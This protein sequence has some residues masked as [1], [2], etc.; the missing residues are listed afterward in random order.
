MK[1]DLTEHS[2]PVYE[3]LASPVRL[4]VLRLLA[5][6]PM[7]IKELAGAVGLSSAIMTMHVRKLAEAGL[8]ATQMAPGK[9]GLQKICSLAVSQTEI[10][11]SG[12]SPGHKSHRVEIPVGHYSDFRIEPTCGLATPDKII[13]NFDD[14]RYF[15]EPERINAGVLWLGKGFI[16]YKAPNYLLSSQQ[17]R[18]LV[19]TMEIASEA[20]ATNNNYPSDI[21]FTFN[22][23]VVGVWTSPGD[24]GDRKGKY[25]P[26]WW[27]AYTN[28]YGLLKQ[29]RITDE[30]TFMDGQK[31]SDI[32]L[33][34]VDIRRK[35]WTFRLSVEEEARHQGGL[36]LF[37][38]GFGNYNEHLS[39]ELFYD[40]AH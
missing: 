3:A 28:Q 12:S 11:L 4:R 2:L 33:G 7:N 13:G 23:V 30:G 20:P 32:V 14:P 36:T 35:Q 8:I 39:A 31:L 37:G 40:E 34:D 15:W 27:P 10:R 25:T 19:L 9:S 38:K 1:L 17:P 21:T 16:E 6:R 22:G 29:L 5:E 18:E 24:Y 26:E